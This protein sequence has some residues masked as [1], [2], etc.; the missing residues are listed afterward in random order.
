MDAVEYLKNQGRMC[1]EIKNCDNCSLGKA[2]DA[3]NSFDCNDY[4]ISYPEEAVAIVEQWA[5]EHP[6]K[7]YKDKLFEL[8]PKMKE[9]PIER[10][11]CKLHMFEGE[12]C[13]KLDWN[14][15]DCQACWNEEYKEE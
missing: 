8:F 5:K 14:I 2:V 15:E 9:L 6:V 10:V 1:K 11:Y 7:T 12:N 3:T 13:P 4:G